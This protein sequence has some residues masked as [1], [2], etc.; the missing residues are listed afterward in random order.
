MQSQKATGY[1]ELKKFRQCFIYKQ[2]YFMVETFLNCD[3]QPT[4]LRIENSKER[5]EIQIPPL[6]K[7]SKK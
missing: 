2:Q 5:S 6:F 7:S 4:L 3:G 1:K